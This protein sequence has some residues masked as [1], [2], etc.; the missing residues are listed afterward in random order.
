MLPVRALVTAGPLLALASPALAHGGTEGPP[1]WTFEP[2]LVVSLT[3]SLGL[4]VIGAARL[5]RRS[6]HGRSDLARHSVLFAAGWLV[7]ALATVSPLHEK[8][9]SAVRSMVLRKETN[10]VMDELWDLGAR[11]IFVTDIHACRL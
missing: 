7:L 9:W 6:E 4:F 8:G 1:G 11:A 10:R 5:A 2:W 3:L